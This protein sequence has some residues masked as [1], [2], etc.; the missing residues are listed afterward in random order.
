MGL[1][2]PSFCQEDDIQNFIIFTRAEVYGYSGDKIN[3]LAWTGISLLIAYAVLVV[4]ATILKSLK[5]EK[6][7]LQKKKIS[8]K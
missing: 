1:C 6:L 7:A 3:A 8:E 5:N 4:T 2:V